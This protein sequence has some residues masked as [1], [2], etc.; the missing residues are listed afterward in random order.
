[1]IRNKAVVSYIQGAT[2]MSIIFFL[3]LKFVFD[4]TWFV[5]LSISIVTCVVLSI[6]S[7]FRFKEK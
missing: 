1:M 2:I 7:V 6:T 5:S 4:S 3:V